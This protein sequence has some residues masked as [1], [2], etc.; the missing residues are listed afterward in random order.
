MK[1]IL[2]CAGY[3]TRLYPLTKEKPKPLLTVADKPIIEY[4]LAD[5]A[6]IDVIDEI[7]VVTNDK[8]AGNFESWAEMFTYGKKIVIVN[9]H[10]LSN[11]DRLGAIGDIQYTIEE[12]HI[13]DDLLIIAGDNIF[14]LDLKDFISYARTHEPFAT[15]AAYDVK[16]RALARQYGLVKTD[17]SGI[18]IDFQEKPA[19][20]ETTLASLGLY[21]YPRVL[22]G[23]IAAYIKDGNNPDQPGN[24]VAWI[25][26]QQSVYSYAFSGVWFDV[27]DFDSLEKANTYFKNKQ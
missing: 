17:D 13:D 4:L 12:Q 9:D 22:L 23:S 27:G 6:M 26:K 19:E 21:Y 18:V 8:F 7:Y 24:F 15:I 2:L 14:D 16:D 1:V 5:I 11:D 10:T 25:S 3:A 20:P